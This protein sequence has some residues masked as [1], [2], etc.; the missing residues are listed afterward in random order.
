MT[1]STNKT[2][3]VRLV[4]QY[5]AYKKECKKHGVLGRHF[6]DWKEYYNVNKGNIE[7]D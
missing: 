7:N 4:K 5:E 2:E 1:Y 6:E 3:H